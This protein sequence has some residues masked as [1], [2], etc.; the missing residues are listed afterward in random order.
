MHPSQDFPAA[1][2]IAPAQFERCVKV[3]AGNDNRP[4]ETE[5]FLVVEDIPAVSWLSFY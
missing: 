1:W 5:S 4:D 2:L 3:A